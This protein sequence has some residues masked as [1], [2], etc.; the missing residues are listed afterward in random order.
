M[1]SINDLLGDAHD[2]SRVV[3]RARMSTRAVLFSLPEDES[4]GGEWVLTWHAMTRGDLA[5]AIAVM[6]AEFTRIYLEDD[7]E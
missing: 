5:H 6:Q 2:K 4:D 1:S 7:D 3:E